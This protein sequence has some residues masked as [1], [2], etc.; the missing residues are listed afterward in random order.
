MLSVEKFSCQFGRAEKTKNEKEKKNQN[1]EDPCEKGAD[2]ETRADQ[3]GLANSTE[4][5]P[6][7]LSG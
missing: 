7:P 5:I 3:M 4:Y 1:K 6:G 2:L